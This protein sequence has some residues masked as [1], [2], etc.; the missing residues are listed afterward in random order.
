MLYNNWENTGL[1][2][3]LNDRQ[4]WLCSDAFDQAY[5]FLLMEHEV[6]YRTNVD[7]EQPTLDSLL[8]KKIISIQDIRRV[9][10]RKHNLKINYGVLLLPMIRR[11]ITRVD[12]KLDVMDFLFHCNRNILTFD[13]SKY[14]PDADIEA[15]LAAFLSD[16]Y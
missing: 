1:L 16:S 9:F 3:G 8:A 11:I 4:K 14:R 12:A 6:E 5:P 13:P 7:R 2:E 10:G 15:E